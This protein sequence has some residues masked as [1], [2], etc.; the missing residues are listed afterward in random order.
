M[1]KKIKSL[2]KTKKLIKHG[3]TPNILALK[4]NLEE[5]LGEFLVKQESLGEEFEK[6]LY[7]NLDQLLI[8]S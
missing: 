1:N 2:G 6:I 8:K 4:I 7:N 5:H 3:T